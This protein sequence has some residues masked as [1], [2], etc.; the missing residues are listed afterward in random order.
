[1]EVRASARSGI[2]AS[3]PLYAED[4]TRVVETEVC[5][6]EAAVRA[7][8]PAAVWIELEP[9]G[10]DSEAGLFFARHLHAAA[11]AV[12]AGAPMA[13]MT[14]G[15]GGG[16]DTLVQQQDQLVR[17]WHERKA[18][19]AAAAVGPTPVA[20]AVALPPASRR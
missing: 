8:H 5:A 1:V 20:E 2:G 18:A 6:I 3:W 12:A 15:D 19:A 7:A 14:A 10:R 11:A 4:V 16:G 9:G 13:P 17:R